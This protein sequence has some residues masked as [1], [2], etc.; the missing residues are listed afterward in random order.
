MVE[1]PGNV[2]GPTLRRFLNWRVS[3]GAGLEISLELTLVLQPRFSNNAM[4]VQ[5]RR[6]S[7]S[8][9]ES[10][11]FNLTYGEVRF[12]IE[13]EKEG[14]SNCEGREADLALP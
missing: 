7:T 10:I 11:E 4:R 3:N 5:R 13:E 1:R 14:F 8:T 9:F 2:A 6:W 12:S